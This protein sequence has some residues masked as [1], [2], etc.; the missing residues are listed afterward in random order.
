MS[1]GTLYG[2]NVATCTQRVNL[3]AKEN[4]VEVTPSFVDLMAGQQKQEAHLAR[5]VCTYVLHSK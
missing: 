3:I 4:N 1:V 5:Q 2:W